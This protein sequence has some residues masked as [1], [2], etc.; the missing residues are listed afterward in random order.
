MS[1]LQFVRSF[2][3]VYHGVCDELRRLVSVR[4]LTE[5]LPDFL[6]R[7]KLDCSS[8]CSLL[9]RDRYRVEHRRQLFSGVTA[10]QV[11]L[12]HMASI[13]HPATLTTHTDNINLLQAAKNH[14]Y[15]WAKE[16]NMHF[17]AGKLLTPRYQTTCPCRPTTKILWA[18]RNTNLT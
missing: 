13:I 5:Q 16:N 9:Q 2:N 3:E 8:Q 10:I 12:S 4:K 11:A 14:L 1:Y 7:Q 15:E 17:D 6:K 18:T